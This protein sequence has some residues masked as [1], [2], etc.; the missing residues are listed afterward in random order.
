MW[1]FPKIRATLFGVLIIRIL[2]FE[3]LYQGPL[4]SETPTYGDLDG[5][6]VKDHVQARGSPLAICTGVSGPAWA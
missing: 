3:V 5:A 2:L 6:A 4:F 1:E